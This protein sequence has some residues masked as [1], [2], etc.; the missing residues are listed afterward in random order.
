MTLFTESHTIKIKDIEFIWEYVIIPSNT[1]EQISFVNG[2]A[3]NQ[4]GRHVDYILNQIVNR[5]KELLET[6]GQQCFN[7]LNS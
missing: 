2:N 5:L 1:Y 6:K 4:G 7:S 3:T